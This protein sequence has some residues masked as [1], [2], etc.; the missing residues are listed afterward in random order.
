MNQPARDA[1]KRPTEL[2]C[3]LSKLPIVR[4]ARTT[5][6]PVLVVLD[7]ETLEVLH[8]SGGDL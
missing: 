6:R 2:S 4:A 5:K 1:S 3:V 7:K 8:T